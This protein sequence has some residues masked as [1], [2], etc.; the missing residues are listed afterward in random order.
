MADCRLTLAELGLTAQGGREAQVT[1]LSV[2]SRQVRPG[3]L[4][5]ALGGS[6]VHGAEFI[7]YAIRMDAAAILTDANGGRGSRP[8]P[9]PVGPARW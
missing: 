1:G 5:A 6:K 7:P 4:F 8:R 2:D 9:W 3:H